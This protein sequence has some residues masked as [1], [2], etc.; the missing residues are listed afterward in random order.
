MILIFFNVSN[1]FTESPIP[2]ES[3][4]DFT[5]RI[6]FNAGSGKFIIDLNKTQSTLQIYSNSIVVYL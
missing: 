5:S 2:G 4:E 6:Q 3:E 1:I